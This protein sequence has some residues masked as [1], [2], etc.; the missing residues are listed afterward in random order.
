MMAFSLLILRQAFK[1][2]KLFFKSKKRI[3]KIFNRRKKL[4]YKIEKLII[5]NKK[6][7][8]LFLKNYFKVKN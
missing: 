6:K 3:I 5:Q 4:K 1:Q 8:K 2:P 7:H